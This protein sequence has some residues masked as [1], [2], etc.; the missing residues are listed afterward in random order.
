MSTP[1]PRPETSF[2]VAA[3]AE[4]LAAGRFQRVLTRFAPE[5]NA[6]LHLGHANIIR[7]CSRPFLFADP[8]EMDRVLIRNW[9]R[10][11]GPGSR[12]STSFRRARGSFCFSRMA[13]R[14]G[15]SWLGGAWY[16]RARARGEAHRGDKCGL[17]CATWRPTA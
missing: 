1:E 6:Y 5:P 17:R 15:I 3:A 16:A 7:Y 14:I 12:I 10:T 11:A 8:G 4:D 2:L 9:N 13:A